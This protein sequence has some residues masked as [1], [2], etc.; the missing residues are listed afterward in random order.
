MVS[1]RNPQSDG[2]SYEPS[3]DQLYQQSRKAMQI[4]IHAGFQA[5]LAGGCVRDRLLGVRP[6]D[7]DIATDAVPDE[8]CTVF[9]QK[10]IKVVPTG[11]DHGTITV[12]MAGQAIEVTTLR[13]DVSTDGRRAV[14]AFS[15]SFE[16]DAARRDLTINA[17][18]E[19]IDGRI[20]DSVGGEADLKAKRLRFV[21]DA[22]TR[23]REDFLRILRLFR[24]WARLEFVPEPDLLPKLAQ[25]APGLAQISQERKTSE[26]LQILQC[27]AILPVLKAMAESSV[28][29]QLLSL[30]NLPVEL[31]PFIDALP[32]ARQLELARLALLLEKTEGDLRTKLIALR[33]SSQQSETVLALVSKEWPDPQLP[34]SQLM[35]SIDA[36]DSKLG[37]GAFENLLFPYWTAR[38]PQEK[39]R[40]DALL[41]AAKNPRRKMRMPLDGSHLAKHLGLAPGAEL[42]ARLL[43]LKRSFRDGLWSTA[44][45][46]LE[47]LKKRD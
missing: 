34:A 1:P 37:E 8:V 19:D 25:E 5:R 4:L 14:V 30:K 24:F 9:K 31:E 20:Y 7:F 45:E 43:D 12:V 15:R 33:L 29:D 16:E 46:G 32:L 47:R 11:V 41:L 17:L 22:S 13:R 26:L 23:M 38:Y 42:G 44:E 28:L 36:W 10:N 21:G 18:Y 40:L 39:G 3:Q 27:K 6:K 35:E 2:P